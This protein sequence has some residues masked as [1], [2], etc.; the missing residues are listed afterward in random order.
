MRDGQL[1]ERVRLDSGGEIGELQESINS[2]AQSLEEARQ[3]LEERIAERTHALTASRNQV[4]LENA[5]KRRLIKRCT[6]S[7]RRS[8]A[9][10]R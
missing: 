2:M 3:D 8:V 7:L 5:E 9:V 10:L 6:T 1:Q 4:L